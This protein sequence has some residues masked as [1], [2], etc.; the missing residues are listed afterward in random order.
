MAWKCSCGVRLPK[1]G[2]IWSWRYRK[3]LAKGRPINSGYYCDP[4]ADAREQGI[5]LNY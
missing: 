5:D 1:K 4:C 2:T 3:W